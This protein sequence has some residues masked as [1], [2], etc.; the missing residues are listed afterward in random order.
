MLR[1][2]P[3]SPP[4]VAVA[5]PIR[6]SKTPPPWSSIASTSPTMSRRIACSTMAESGISTL[7]SI[8]IDCA[9]ASIEAASDR[10]R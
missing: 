3:A 1:N 10:M 2:C 9:R 8:A 4:V 6:T 7:C 5:R